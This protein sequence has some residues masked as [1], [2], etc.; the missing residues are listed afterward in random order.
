[1]GITLLNHRFSSLQDYRRACLFVDLV[2]A[3]SRF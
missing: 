2:N 1:M 3:F